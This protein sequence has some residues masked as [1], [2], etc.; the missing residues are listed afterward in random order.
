MTRQEIERMAEEKIRERIV[1]LCKEIKEWLREKGKQLSPDLIRLTV[2]IHILRRP[3]FWTC[4][5]RT[6]SEVEPRI[7][8]LVNEVATDEMLEGL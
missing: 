5:G 8:T 4:F 7:R 2:L 3:H 1:S 6:E